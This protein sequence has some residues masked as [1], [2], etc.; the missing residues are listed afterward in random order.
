MANADR[1]AAF[2]STEV[3]WESVLAVAEEHGVQGMLARRLEEIE[4]ADV[5]ATAREKIQ[6]QMR[7]HHLLALSLNAELF[8]ILDDFA[9]AG[10][11][12][13]PVKGPVLSQIA[14]GDPARRCFGELDLLL[15]Q[16]RK[17]VV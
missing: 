17:S 10:V 1:V 7:A 2:L 5:P 13:I 4:Y 16:D 6:I 9:K 12:A 14:Y 15:P 8:R 11:E 3:D